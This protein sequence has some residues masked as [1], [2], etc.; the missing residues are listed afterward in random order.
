METQTTETTTNT[1]PQEMLPPGQTFEQYSAELS[2]KAGGEQPVAKAEAAKPSRPDHVP[3]K[4]WDAD[5]GEVRLDA[6]LKSQTE[7]EKRFSKGEHKQG[8]KIGEDGQAAAEATTDTGAHADFNTAW[9]SF[10]SAV[11]TKG[12]L[13][14]ADY[15][16]LEKFVPRSLIDEQ[17]AMRADLLAAQA[18][19]QTLK[20]ASYEQEIFDLAGDKDKY[21]QMVTWAQANFTADE[22]KQYD[23]LINDPS[24]GKFAL[25][26]LKARFNAA[27]PGE[28]TRIQAQTSATTG[29]VFRDQTELTAAINSNEYRKSEAFRSDVEAKIARSIKAGTLR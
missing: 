16:V 13:E 27:N 10:K 24:A 26:S 11:E 21:N 17:M 6:L 9:D 12:A 2:A 23:T 14:D 25:E 1:L 19:L 5:K 3:E 18:E 8:L 4:F 22:I 7:L 15:A 20:T 29:D 28:G